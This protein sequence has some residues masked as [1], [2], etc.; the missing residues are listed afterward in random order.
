MTKL[1]CILISV[2]VTQIYT[3]ADIHRIVHSKKVKPII[4]C[5]KLKNKIG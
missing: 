5:V 2:V 1:F 4:L 3:D